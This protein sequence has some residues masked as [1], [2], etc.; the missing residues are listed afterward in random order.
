MFHTIV[1]HLFINVKI[2]FFIDC[3]AT[4]QELY[5]NGKSKKKSRFASGF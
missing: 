4:I 5:T 3:R 1:T 2:L